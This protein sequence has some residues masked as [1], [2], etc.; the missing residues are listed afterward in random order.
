MLLTGGMS[1]KTIVLMLHALMSM[2]KLAHTQRGHVL[3]TSLLVNM[4]AIFLQCEQ[5]ELPR[6]S[7]MHIQT[8]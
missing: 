5:T 3:G 8:H 7:Y 2:W 1:Y 4:A 6:P